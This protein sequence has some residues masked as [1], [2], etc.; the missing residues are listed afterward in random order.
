MQDLWKD[1]QTD[2]NCEDNFQKN[3]RI[4]IVSE[5]REIS[6]KRGKGLMQTLDYYTDEL[7]KIETQ[8]IYL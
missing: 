8:P 4:M 2:L 5:L 1:T 6:A 7:K 3:N